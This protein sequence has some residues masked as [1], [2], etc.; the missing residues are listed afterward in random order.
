MERTRSGTALS[1]R[2]IAVLYLLFF[3]I[4]CVLRYLTFLLA[5]RAIFATYAVYA[6]SVVLSVAFI[7]SYPQQ[8]LGKVLA[9][10]L[11]KAELYLVLFYGANYIL[12]P[13]HRISMARNA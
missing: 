3:G 6:V 4:T 5:G 8:K 9:K 10:K 2:I 13:D 7:Y 1:Y 11:M 12:F